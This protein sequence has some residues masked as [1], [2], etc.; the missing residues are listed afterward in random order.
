MRQVKDKQPTGMIGSTWENGE[1]SKLKLYPDGYLRPLLMKDVPFGKEYYRYAH[2]RMNAVAIGVNLFVPWFLFT[3][4]FAMVAFHVHYDHPMTCICLCLVPFIIGA[5]LICAKIVDHLSLKFHEELEY[6]EL[7]P[8]WHVFL[9]VTCLLAFALACMF[10]QMTFV[11]YS[12]PYYNLKNLNTYT[13]ID[14]AA[15]Q[16]D[17]LMDAGT[18]MWQE[19]TKVDVS[20]S[21]GFKDDEMFCVAPI[22]TNEAKQET[23]DF[24]AIGKNCCTGNQPDFRCPEVE[25]TRA[26]GSVRLLSDADR[27]FYRLAVQQAEGMYKI[28]A[29]HPVFFTWED[30]P[31]KKQEEMMLRCRTNFYYASMTYFVFQ[32]FI[33]LAATL[34][35]AQW[36]PRYY[37]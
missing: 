3:Y 24:W 14:T 26:R 25:N 36:A 21:M 4:V 17:M 6:T 2:K 22:I 11:T 16:G 10:G 34:A 20:K 33:V 8:N 29:N 5:I 18:V 30:E 9:I 37:N 23:Y 28:R 19:G 13:N 12:V 7:E 32:L 1:D 27:P 31:L 35:A 15:Y